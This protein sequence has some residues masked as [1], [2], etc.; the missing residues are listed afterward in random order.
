MVTDEQV[1][2]M[3]QKRM[4]G[5]SQDAAAAAAGMSVR[6]ART[7]AKGR[8]PSDRKVPRDWRTRT[9]PLAK[10]WESHVVPLLDA[11]AEGIL[12]ATV[13][14]EELQERCPG[15][16]SGGQLRTLQRRMRDWRALH[17][18]DKE[19]Y[20]QQ[21]HPPGREAAM[22]FTH[23]TSLGVTIG[24]EALAHLL[25]TL[26][27]SFSGWTWVRVAFGETFEALVCGIQDALWAL[28][29][30]TEVLRHDNLSAATHE[31]RRSGGRALNSRF[32]DVM[33][34]YGLRSTRIRVGE[35]HENGVAEKN[36]DL[37]K[38]AVAQ[39]LVLRGSR[40]FES[41]EA[42]EGWLQQLVERRLNQ[43][44]ADKVA[45]ERE[46]L[47]PLPTCR[48]PDYT[49]YH[50][51]V[52]RWSTIRIGKRCYSVPSR[53]IGHRVEAR[54]YPDVVEVLYRGRL[55]ETMPRLHGGQEVRIDYRHIISSL[56]RKP[57]AFRRYR[58][59]E[60]LFPSLTFRRAYDALCSWRGERGDIEYVRVLHLAATTMESLVERALGELLQQG[61]P[62]DYVRV[63]ELANP[64]PILVPEISLPAPDLSAYD[65]LLTVR[66]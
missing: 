42:Y 30:V 5:K 61:E 2:L 60:E 32:R 23:A 63:K 35:A 59:R 34:H 62:F 27:L 47:R 12:Q 64:E 25:F 11:D 17:G 7:W 29:G 45:V 38:R 36:N 21:E 54:Q 22:D 49:R 20:F 14:L 13:V 28:G 10:V 66:P 24:G 15:K 57:G 39:A 52:R 4:E 41:L 58:Y 6:T 43:P 8:L 44:R 65:R 40:D 1:R 31:L 56:V 37:V 19:V 33:E 18:P 53:L 51:T 46:H 9:D 50:P 48:V 3:R 26:K 16:V 55:V